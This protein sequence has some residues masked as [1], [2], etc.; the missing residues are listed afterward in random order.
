MTCKLGPSEW[1]QK[2]GGYDS[3][4][5]SYANE[6]HKMAAKMLKKFEAGERFVI[7]YPRY[8]YDPIKEEERIKR[9][10]DKWEKE[11]S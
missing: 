6:F 8:L 11:S 4:E 10:I 9:L 5:S 3:E 2:Y 1:I 7:K